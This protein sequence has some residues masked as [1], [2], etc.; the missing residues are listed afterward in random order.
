MPSA[1]TTTTTSPTQGPIDDDVFDD[2]TPRERVIVVE[3]AGQLLAI[4]AGRIREVQ[5]T[6][7]TVRVPGAPPVMFGIANLRG[8]VVTVL[9]LAV[10]LEAPLSSSQEWPLML[11][12]GAP[13]P[14]SGADTGSIVLLEHGAQL[15]GLRVDAVRSIPARDDA[16]LAPVSLVSQLL[17]TAPTEAPLV[18]AVR[19]GGEDF[20]LLDVTALLTRYLLPSKE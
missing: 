9:D 18:G 4:P 3:S 7:R 20:P 15:V 1:S 19:A 8:N 17:A 10:A 13:V 2:D 12:A 16:P 6:A 14:T 11:A 5:R